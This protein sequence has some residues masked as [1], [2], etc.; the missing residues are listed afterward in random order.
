VVTGEKTV[1]KFPSSTTTFLS[2]MMRP[3]KGFARTTPNYESGYEAD[4]PF[5]S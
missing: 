3:M 2:P 1:F 4:A 5:D